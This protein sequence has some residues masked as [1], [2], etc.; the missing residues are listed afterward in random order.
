MLPRGPLRAVLFDWDG[1]LLDS[2]QAD[3]RAYL[4]MFRAL[5]I[6]WG[7]QELE[8]HYSPNWH[9]VYRA[10]GLAQESWGEADL[11]WRACYRDHPPV[12]Q[13]GA[14][15]VVHR[16]ARSYRLGLVTSGSGVRVRTQLRA[17]GL[18]GL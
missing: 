5:G 16:L 18:D 13:H 11:V 14:D 6:P 3:A 9:Q 8:R 1:T 4:Q 12:L 7:L 17:F 10:A 2:Y 15:R